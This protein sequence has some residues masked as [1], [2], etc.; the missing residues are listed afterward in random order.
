MVEGLIQNL[1]AGFGISDIQE[2]LLIFLH[3]Q[4]THTFQ[5]SKYCFRLP[6]G[7]PRQSIYLCVAL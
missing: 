5:P 3:I 4:Q 6:F 2:N 1:K 7:S